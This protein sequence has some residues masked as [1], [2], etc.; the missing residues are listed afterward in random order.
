MGIRLGVI[1]ALLL[2]V[3]TSSGCGGVC[4]FLEIGSAQEI[5]VDQFA[6]L[7]DE[8]VLA[9]SEGSCGQG[10]VPIDCARSA[11]IELPNGSMTPADL[12]GLRDHLADRGW[13]QCEDIGTYGRCYRIEEYDWDRGIVEVQFSHLAD[14]PCS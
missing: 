3:V 6:P 1:V 8:Y 13:E 2:T 5:N 4:R 10:E 11:T 7:P 14:P 12:G 9:D